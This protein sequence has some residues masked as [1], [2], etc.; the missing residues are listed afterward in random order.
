MKGGFFIKKIIILILIIITF[1]SIV[2]RQEETIRFRVIANSNTRSDQLDKKKIV[3]NLMPSILDIIKNSDNIE[4]TRKSIKENMGNFKNNIE[5]TIKEEEINTSYNINYGDNYFPEKEYKD[6]KYK[7]GNYESLVIT[8]GEGKGD[9]F[10]CILF[11][12]LCLLEAE[13]NKSNDIEYKSI[14]KELIDKYL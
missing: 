11:P 3:N 9:N 7:A 14:I 13:D 10:W 12:P 1:I 5:E 2:S 4:T 8:L 6:K